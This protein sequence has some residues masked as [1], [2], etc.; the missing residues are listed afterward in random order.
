M[1]SRLMDFE[2]GLDLTGNEESSIQGGASSGIDIFAF[3]QGTDF[4]NAFTKTRSFGFTLRDGRR[5]SV[6]FGGG[7]SIGVDNP[8]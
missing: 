8:E 4:A 1:S 5:V 7:F 2:L 6:A 3:A